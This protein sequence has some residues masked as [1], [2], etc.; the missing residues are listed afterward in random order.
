MLQRIDFL[1]F[2]IT[3]HILPGLATIKNSSD[4]KS[5]IQGIAGNVSWESMIDP[6]LFFPKALNINLVWQVF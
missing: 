2:F 3:M 4:K 6:A 1:T 5:N